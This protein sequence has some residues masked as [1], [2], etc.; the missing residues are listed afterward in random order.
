MHIAD[1][2]DM[3]RLVGTSV[4]LVRDDVVGVPLRTA[5][6]VIGVTERRLQLWAERGLVKPTSQRRVGRRRA[7]EYSLEDLVQGRIVHDLEARGVHIRHIAGIVAAVRSD[8]HPQPLA[9]L[10]W[11]VSAG[12][13]FVQFPDGRWY[14]GKQPNQSVL[15]ETL[16]LDKI[17]ADARQRLSRPVELGGQIERRRGTHGNREVFAGS[18]VP[19]ETVQRYIEAGRSSEQ[20]LA[21]FPVLYPADIDEARRRAS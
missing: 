11:G 8:E 5:G 20:I 10:R 7:W 17:R 9:S 16:N 13:V 21:S 1:R 12:E 4:E 3:L 2:C 15:A 18:R 19:V 14:G 6:K